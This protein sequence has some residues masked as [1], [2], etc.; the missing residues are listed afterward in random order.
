MPLSAAYYYLSGYD[1]TLQPPGYYVASLVPGAVG[2]DPAN[3]KWAGQ[4]SG[5]TEAAVTW[6]GIVASV[7]VGPVRGPIR[8]H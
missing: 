8:T 2:Y 4:L 6:P 3:A 5:F 7:T 1:L